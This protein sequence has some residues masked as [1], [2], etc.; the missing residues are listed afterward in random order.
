MQ[1]R[2]ARERPKSER[3]RVIKFLCGRCCYFG[4]LVT[5][6]LSGKYRISVP[7]AALLGVNTKVREEPNLRAKIEL[8]F[9]TIIVEI[10]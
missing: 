4:G 3:S 1:T 5:N 2:R 9:D 7:P 8:H 6:S 10:G